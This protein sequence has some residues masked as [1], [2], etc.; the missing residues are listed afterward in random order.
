MS[1]SSLLDKLNSL[2]E[3]GNNHFKQNN[4][5]SAIQYFSEAIELTKQNHEVYQL[6][7]SIFKEVVTSLYTNR[8]LAYS[9]QTGKETEI[10]EDANHVLYHIDSKNVKALFWRAMVH[11]ARK[12]F[13]HAVKDLNTLLEHDK[14]NKQAKDEL[15]VLEKLWKEESKKP[16]KKV[17]PQEVKKEE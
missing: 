4:Y 9:K 7:K 14:V 10:L 15:V 3:T 11:K 13:D 2:K 12:D 17:E 6:N 5:S 8:C 16:E 1:A